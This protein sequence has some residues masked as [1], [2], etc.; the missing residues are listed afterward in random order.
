MKDN[1]R[2]LHTLP[3]PAGAQHIWD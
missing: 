1:S 2:K 3:T